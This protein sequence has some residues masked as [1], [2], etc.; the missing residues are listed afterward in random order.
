[1][2]VG[3]MIAVRHFCKRTVLVRALLKSKWKIGR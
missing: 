3:A 2:T 1:M